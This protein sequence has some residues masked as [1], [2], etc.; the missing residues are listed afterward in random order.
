MAKTGS[1]NVLMRR[2]RNGASVVF[3]PWIKYSP[4]TDT[5]LLYFYGGPEP[6]VNLDVEGTSLYLMTK[7]DTNEL[8]GVHIQAFAKRFL[9]EH[10]YFRQMEAVQRLVSN[11]DALAETSASE[12]DFS[13]SLAEMVVGNLVLEHGLLAS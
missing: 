9:S 8:V 1:M 2:S 6:A 10:P 7:P 13:R 5:L 3:M 11:T 12:D 4:L